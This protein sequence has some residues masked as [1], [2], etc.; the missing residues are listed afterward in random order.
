[1]RVKDRGRF[2][3]VVD[4]FQQPSGS[5]AN[6]GDYIGI[7]TR[8]IAALPAITAADCPVVTLRGS[9]ETKRSPQLPYTFIGEAEW[10]GCT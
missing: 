10:N 1:L 6:L 5:F 9:I 4:Q 8:A 3:R 7:G 2:E